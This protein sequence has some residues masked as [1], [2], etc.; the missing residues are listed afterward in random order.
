MD[1]PGIVHKITHFLSERGIN[2]AR[3]ETRLSHAPVT[4]TPV[5]SLTLDAELP[6]DLPLARLRSDLSAL[7]ADENIDID[8]RP[9]E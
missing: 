4:G 1:H 2:L 9:T 6:A 3:L 8:L 5:F 7:A